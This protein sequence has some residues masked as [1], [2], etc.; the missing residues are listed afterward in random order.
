MDGYNSV[1]GAQKLANR[2]TCSDRRN[3]LK[4]HIKRTKLLISLNYKQN[5]MTILSFPFIREMPNNNKM[6]E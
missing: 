1:R 2:S 3:N 4:S 5:L 6:Y